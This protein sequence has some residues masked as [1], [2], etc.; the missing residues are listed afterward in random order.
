MAKAG[1]KKGKGGFRGMPMGKS[2]THGIGSEVT[3]I[4]ITKDRRRQ[5]MRVIKGDATMIGKTDKFM[6]ELLARNLA[7][8][9][10]MDDWL[11]KEGMFTELGEMQP[12]LK[13]YWMAINTATRQMDQLGLTPSSR[14]RMGLSLDTHQDLATAIHSG[15]GGNGDKELDESELSRI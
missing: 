3:L 5:I 4:D 11:D 14:L 8:I 1:R 6:V 7:K 15:N 13:F 9:Q 2:C 10:L 12:V